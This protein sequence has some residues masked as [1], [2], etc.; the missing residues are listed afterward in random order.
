MRALGAANRVRLREFQHSGLNVSEGYAP[1]ELATLV[2]NEIRLPV[3]RP[4]DEAT[5]AIHVRYLS[6]SNDLRALES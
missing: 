3:V 5:A 2:A 6:M 1:N 4:D